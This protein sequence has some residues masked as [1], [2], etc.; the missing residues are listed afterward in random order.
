M[1]A[2]LSNPRDIAVM[3]LRDREGNVS[4]HLESRLSR[5]QLKPANAALARELALGAHRRRATLDAVLRGYLAQPDRRLPGSLQEILWVAL[6]QVLMLDRVPAHAAVNEAVKQA[7]RFRHRRQAGLVNGVLRAVTRSVSDLETGPVPVARDVIPVGPESFRRL[8]KPAFADP[9]ARPAA[10]LAAAYS[11]PEVLAR[12]WLGR[13]GSLEAAVGVAAHANARAPLILRVNTSAVAVDAV[14][15]ELAEA[16]VYAHPHANGTSVVLDGYTDV[17]RLGPF[18]RGVVQPQ[19]PSATAVVAAAD[20]RPGMR[21]LDFCAAPGTKTTHLAERMG[22]EGSIVALDVSEEKLSRIEDNCRRMGVEIV[23]T[24]LAGTAGQLEV[25]AFDLVLA[26]VPC[27][28]TGVL[29]RRAEARWR[30]S[31]R[32]LS[33][34]VED[35]KFLIR[36]AGR[37]VRPGGRLVYSTCSIEPEEGPQVAQWYVQHES[38]MRLV[39]GELTLPAGATDPTQWRDGGYVGVLEG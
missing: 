33:S 7:G 27:S 21:V 38:R 22:N 8:E 16:G 5:Q 35:Q 23:E 28:N 39:K 12:R 10:Y 15:A 4:A 31:E 32:A 3:A 2:E 34:L 36:A 18:E 1:T 25:G 14:V 29:S 26:D 20:S 37:F 30:F 19:D 13:L 11:L 9:A 24:R 6:Y 17:T